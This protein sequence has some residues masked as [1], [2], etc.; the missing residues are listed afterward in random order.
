VN[1]G[2]GFENIHRETEGHLELVA[3]GTAATAGER[4]SQYALSKDARHTV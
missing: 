1:I 4:K 2:E 3:R